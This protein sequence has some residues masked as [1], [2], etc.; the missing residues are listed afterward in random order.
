V[1]NG[2]RAASSL[3]CPRRPLRQPAE[4]NDEALLNSFE[5]RLSRALGVLPSDANAMIDYCGQEL[6]C[7]GNQSAHKLGSTLELARVARSLAIEWLLL[8]SGRVQ[9]AS[10]SSASSTRAR[11]SVASISSL[12][13]TTSRS[14]TL[15]M[16]STMT[17]FPSPGRWC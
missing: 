5:E 8:I 12:G 1:S 10:P 9:A 13:A 4:T 3:P 2:A 6:E 16:S 17:L 11:D 15:V 14:T 7:V